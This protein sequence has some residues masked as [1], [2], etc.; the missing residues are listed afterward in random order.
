MTDWK[1]LYTD[2]SQMLEVYQSEIVP[3]MRKQIAELDAYNKRLLN[4][5]EVVR[6]EDCAHTR[7][8]T[9]REQSMYNENVYICTKDDIWGIPKDEPVWGDSFCNDGERRTK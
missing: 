4:R 7:Q 2:A 9:N 8:K 3:G 1:R 6:C 5:V